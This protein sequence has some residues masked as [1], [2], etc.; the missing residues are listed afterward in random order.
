MWLAI[1]AIF[2]TTLLYITL[3]LPFNKGRQQISRGWTQLALFGARW[4]CGIR[5]EIIGLEDC[6]KQAAI[7]ICKHQS[8]WETIALPGILP[9]NCFVAKDSLLKIPFFGWGMRICRHIPIDRSSGMS[10]LKKVLRLG[11]ER[12]AEGLSIIIFPEGTRVAPR[13]HPKF[14]KTAMMLAKE[15]GALVVPIAHNSGTCWKRNSFVKYPGKVTVLIG[16]AMDITGLSTEEISNQVYE[17]I[18]AQML[19]LEK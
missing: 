14:H 17:W 9:P 8:A 12:I 4:I 16:P 11:K 7:Y 19:E 3:P 2:F 13:E 10:S 18:K 5:Y 6:P 1:S 15:T